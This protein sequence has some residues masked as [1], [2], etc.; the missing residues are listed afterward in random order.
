MLVSI[1]PSLVKS[2]ITELTGVFADARP[3]DRK[4]SRLPSVTRPIRREPVGDE[5]G[6]WSKPLS[7]IV[8]I[9]SPQGEDEVMDVT[10][11]SRRSLMVAF[12][13]LSL[14]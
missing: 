11:L 5:T 1:S 7:R 9:A 14:S 12:S 3:E 8:S 6:S 2:N 4:E 10:G 13:Y